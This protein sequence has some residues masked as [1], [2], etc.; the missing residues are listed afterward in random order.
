MIYG[1]LVLRP[2]YRT[3][4][5]VFLAQRFRGWLK[6]F[7]FLS[8]ALPP[9]EITV[10]SSSSDGGDGLPMPGP[11][12]YTPQLEMTR[13]S[14]FW[15]IF[16]PCTTCAKP[17]ERRGRTLALADGPLL[18]HFTFPRGKHSPLLAFWVLFHLFIFFKLTRLPNV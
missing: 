5:S 15:C 16:H 7:L 13:A 11:L 6:S 8:P 14:S 1:P 10:T 3:P 2:T 9:M 4:P 17:L 12:P 18:F